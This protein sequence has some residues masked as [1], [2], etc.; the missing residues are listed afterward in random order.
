MPFLVISFSIIAD[1]I[2]VHE[3]HEDLD[4]HF[5][6]QFVV[7]I[8]NKCVPINIMTIVQEI[9]DRQWVDAQ[10]DQVL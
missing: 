2:K 5:A 3:N 7:E 10:F 4:E 9:N 8:Q 1:A 6:N